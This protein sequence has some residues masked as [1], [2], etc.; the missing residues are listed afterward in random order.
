MSFKATYFLAGQSKIHTVEVELTDSTL[1]IKD[2][3]E[4]LNSFDIKDCKFSSI[5]AGIPIE[6]ALPDRGRLEIQSSEAILKKIHDLNIL[7]H[8]SPYY[9]ENKLRY[10]VVGLA[11]TI[12]I[13]FAS[14]KYVIPS[15]SRQVA[16][17]V[18]D[19]VSQFVD[20]RIESQL[21]DF[22]FDESKIDKEVKQKLLKYFK[23][24][25]LDDIKVNFRKGNSAQANA[26]A[27]AGKSIFFTDE[28]I[29]LMNNDKYLLAIAYH[30]AGHLKRHHVLSTI[31][32]DSFIFLL[33]LVYLGD[34]P[35]AADNL[36]Q[37]GLLVYSHDHSREFEKEADDYAI[38]ELVKH[39]IS[40]KCFTEGMN[41]LHEHYEAKSKERFK[42]KKEEDKGES[43]K[44]SKVAAE[45]DKKSE[46]SLMEKFNMDEKLRSVEKILT[47][48]L[49]T[50]P[51]LKERTTDILANYPD[52]KACGGSK[53]ITEVKEN[54]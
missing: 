27:L 6:V 38:K 44:S 50:H 25:G 21:D 39:N 15:M 2:G 42:K 4:V 28:I 45:A 41:K 24:F 20:E 18:P 51:S 48:Y 5:I 26:F 14:F 12:V 43:K 8:Y 29:E 36:M 47:K 34:L 22:I 49:S 16:A 52:A 11:L 10:F 40:P 37:F 33:T 53:I 54:K 9:L 3:T 1:T 13:F 35:A 46:E 31:I 7:K 23:E 17:I 32:K 19:R 30:E